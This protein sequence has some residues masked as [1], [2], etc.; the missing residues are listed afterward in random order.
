MNGAASN[1][2]RSAGGDGTDEIMDPDHLAIAVASIGT[3]HAVVIGAGMAGLAIAQALTA[4]FDRV[5]VVDRDRLP[6]GSDARRGVPQDRHLHLL[7]PAGIDALE[8]LFPGLEDQLCADGARTGDTDRIRMC[9]NGHRLATCPHG[10]PAVFCSRPFLESHVRRRVREDP[11][12]RVR[13]GT[14]ISGLAVANDGGRVEGVELASP[15]GGPPRCCAPRWWWTA[16]DVA[17]RCRDG[18]PTSAT[19]PPRST[20]STSRCATPPAATSS[21][22]RSWTA[23]ITC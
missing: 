2:E 7:L 8:A 15:T 22:M 12:D 21:P 13:D 3:G 19:R 16:R 10:P 1:A 9:L 14:R 11:A 4:G 20:S 5:T 6:T 18:W 23:T 17:R